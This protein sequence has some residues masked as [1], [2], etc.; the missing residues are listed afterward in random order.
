M[1]Q[2]VCFVLETFKHVAVF[3]FNIFHQKVGCIVYIIYRLIMHLS[4]GSKNS[5]TPFTISTSTDIC[6]IIY[7][8]IL[9]IYLLWVIV[10][11]FYELCNILV[12]FLRITRD[13]LFTL[14]AV[15]INQD[16]SPTKR[17]R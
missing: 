12:D 8:L 1:I 10:V 2:A 11:M 15:Q 7:F 14:A 9:F 6:C 3:V 17:D 4:R 13:C 5:I 16:M